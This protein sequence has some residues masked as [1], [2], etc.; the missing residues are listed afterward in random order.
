MPIPVLLPACWKE[1]TGGAFLH[2]GRATIFRQ[3]LTDSKNRQEISAYATVATQICSFHPPYA[4]FPTKRSAHWMAPLLGNNLFPLHYIYYQRNATNS[5]ESTA[6]RKISQHKLANKTTVILDMCNWCR[7]ELHIEGEGA[8]VFFAQRIFFTNVPIP[9]NETL[10]K[11]WYSQNSYFRISLSTN[12]PSHLPFHHWI[13]IPCFFSF[14][15][16]GNMLVEWLQ[17]LM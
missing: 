14:F 11:T 16:V 9:H 6:K 1:K 2:V 7:E 5:I 10:T 3:I 17:Q 8:G 15:G 13:Q 4:Q 12:I